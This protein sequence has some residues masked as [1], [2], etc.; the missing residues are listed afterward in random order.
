VRLRNKLAA[1]LAA[2]F[3]V[4]IMLAG[5][6]A[7]EAAGADTAD[8][9]SSVQTHNGVTGNYCASQEIV[10]AGLELSVPNHAG[11]YSRLTFKVTSTTNRQEDFEWFNPSGPH[12]DNQKLAEW[13]PGG[14]PSGLYLTVSNNGKLLVLKPLQAGGNAAGQQWEADGPDPSG[15]YEWASEANGRAISDPTGAAY[16]R[17]VLVSV[18][19]SSFTYVQ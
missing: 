10:A 1:V 12:A 7:M 14:N 18:G 15:G 11:A 16:A 17:A 9:A 13:A 3:A 19:G 8:C 2:V 6:V 4:V 5:F